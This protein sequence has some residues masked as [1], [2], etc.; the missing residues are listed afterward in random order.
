MHA[1]HTICSKL[2]L[3]HKL[4]VL[5]ENTACQQVIHLHSFLYF[6]YLF[7]IIASA[8]GNMYIR[9]LLSTISA[10]STCNVLIKL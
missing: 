3:N 2:L 9:L 10:L 5:D 1:A 8:N 4:L 6:L 7:A